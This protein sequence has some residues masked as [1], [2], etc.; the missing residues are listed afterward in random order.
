MRKFFYFFAFLF[1]FFV[2]AQNF[3]WNTTY[4][5]GDPSGGC[6]NSFD[7]IVYPLESFIQSNCCSPGQNGTVFVSGNL[8]LPQ[9]YQI[10][11]V[12]FNGVPSSVEVSTRVRAGVGSSV[13]DVFRTEGESPILQNTFQ[14][15]GDCSPSCF[16]LRI[17][18]KFGP[19]A[20]PQNTNASAT[21]NVNYCNGSNCEELAF[22]VTVPVNLLEKPFLE[23]EE[24]PFC[25]DD[26]AEI[27]IKR[28]NHGPQNVCAI[29]F[30]NFTPEE[31]LVWT[32]NNPNILV[33]RSLTGTFTTNR[34]VIRIGLVDPIPTT[35]IIC[36]THTP[37]LQNNIKEWYLPN[38]KICKKVRF[39]DCEYIAP[40]NPPISLR[41]VCS[42]DNEPS[43]YTFATP[44]I[45]NIRITDSDPDL[46]VSV[47]SDGKTICLES[48]HD[49]GPST[50]QVTATFED[51]CGNISSAIWNIKINHGLSCCDEDDP[52]RTSPGNET[53]DPTEAYI[54]EKET[55]KSDKL[56]AFPNPFNHE[57][58]VDLSEIR[59]KITTI[60]LIDAKG[61]TK[62]LETIDANVSRHRFNL[63][64]YQTGVYVVMVY[65]ENLSPVFIKVVKTN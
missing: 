28:N 33:G 9:T 49:C 39:D 35:G 2:N 44:C 26:W 41:N 31:K 61:S 20:A 4:I 5:P 25:V 32:T 1:P 15:D 19:I 17:Y 64:N 38:E 56:F 48:S 55:S 53:S 34:E 46:D 8:P 12:T 14:R 29:P 58:T 65:R 10:S 62:F 7:E 51:K 22:P 40:S 45:D 54:L 3:E 60:Q 57:L 6:I 11:S 43:R 50:S 42:Y 27:A 36:V 59:G 21:F 16:A 23:H 13:V 24:G 37:W 63:Q 30:V 52:M 18:F 47:G